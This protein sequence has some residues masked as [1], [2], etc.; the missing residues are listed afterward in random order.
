MYRTQP[1]R[2]LLPLGTTAHLEMPRELVCVLYDA[3]VHSLIHARAK[4]R[5]WDT[6]GDEQVLK[7]EYKVLAGRM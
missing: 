3:R 5:I 2:V 1:L 7:A 4:V 6:V